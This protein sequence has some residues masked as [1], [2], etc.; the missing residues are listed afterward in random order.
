MLSILLICLKILGMILLICLGIIVFLILAV[1]FV[2]LRYRLQGCFEETKNAKVGVSW[3]GIIFRAVAAYEYEEDINYSVRILGITILT[4]EERRTIIN[5]ILHWK[6]IREEKK[7]K[8][9]YEKYQE[10]YSKFQEEEW[11]NDAWANLPEQKK[12]DWNAWKHSD[13]YKTGYPWDT[14]NEIEEDALSEEEENPL[15]KVKSF[16]GDWKEKRQER[17]KE[18]EREKGTEKS[19]EEPE[20]KWYNDLEDKLEDLSD[21]YE[22]L[23]SFYYE[24]QSQYAVRKMLHLIK[25]TIRYILP[26]KW[27]GTLRYGF[28]DPSMTGKTY[29]MLCALGLPFCDGCCIQPEFQEQ[30]LEGRIKARGRIRVFFFIRVAVMV[31]FDSKLKAVYQKG[32]DVLG[33]I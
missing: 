14:V 33:G 31:F 17:K 19:V 13:K 18:K 5:R 32:K 3:G 8:K 29:G 7:R 11:D 23:E 9:I 16:L 24:N 28:D 6:E 21:K 22:V 15:E 30:V 10:E 26:T 2:P 25:K 1:L 12:Q 4:S 20:E 27:K